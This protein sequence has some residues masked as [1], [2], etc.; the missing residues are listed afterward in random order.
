MPIERLCEHVRPYFES[1][2]IDLSQGPSLA[3]AVDAQRERAKTL[4]DI[5]E[6]S[7]MFYADVTLDEKAAKKHL[8]PVVLEPLTRLRE[9][10][11]AE[12][13]WDGKNL[14]GIIE[15]LAEEYEM[16]MGKIAQPLRVAITGSGASPSIDVT[17]DLVGPERT[18]ARLDKALEYIKKRADA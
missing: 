18:L 10:F 17:L 6:N 15:K 7:R 2:G 12:G 9:A 11:A 3:A 14:H 5:V 1:A 4:L 13:D 8:R 16:N